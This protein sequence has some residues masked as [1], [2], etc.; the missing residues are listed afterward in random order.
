MK[1]FPA[2]LLLL[3]SL[4]LLPAAVRA[5]EAA[6][7]VATGSSVDRDYAAFQETARSGPPA[8][9]KE[10]S[11]ADR[12]RAI[13]ALMQKISG[14]A[15]NFYADHPQDPRRWE[16]VDLLASRRPMFIRSIGPD[17]ET[18]GAKAFVI[19]ESARDAF[20]ARVAE[21]QRAMQTAPDVTPALR[22]NLDWMFFA[23]DFRAATAAMQAGQPVDWAAFGPRFDAHAAKYPEMD[24]TLARRADD[25][26]GALA[27]N[28]AELAAAQ[29]SHLEKDSGSAALR[30]HALEKRQRD[31]A[32]S[33]PQQFA[34]TATD[35]RAVDLKNLR[36][37]V[38]LVDFWATWCGPCVAELPNVKKVYAAYHDK[39]FEVVGIS[40][41]NGRLTPQDTPEQVATKLEA[42]KQVLTEF[43]AKNEMPWPQYFDGKFWKNDISTKYTINSIPAMFLLD[44]EGKVVSTDARGPMLE[45]EI[46]RLLKL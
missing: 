46:K 14:A 37:K 42:A 22:E 7:G 36:G 31:E 10:M 15:L 25:Y 1:E 30:R 2:R 29:W 39:G 12:A 43:T 41:E 16:A 3:S 5:Q 28:G 33:K 24:E 27:K 13:D 11:P 17:F 6:P 38:V 26:L 19:D 21:L 18:V 23:K 45:A 34:F 40:L 4:L 35:G 20:Q 9:F 44:Q 32:M 8:G